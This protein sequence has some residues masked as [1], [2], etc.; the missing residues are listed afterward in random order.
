MEQKGDRPEKVAKC[1]YKE[2][3][4]EKPKILV[5]VGLKNKIFYWFSKFLPK[6]WLFK[7]VRKAFI[8]E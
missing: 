6:K 5:V 7:I 2:L 3:K 1:V 4:K 8:L